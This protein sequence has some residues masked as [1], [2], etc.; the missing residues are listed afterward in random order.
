MNKLIF[1]KYKT[2]AK[3]IKTTFKCPYPM[4]NARTNITKQ[5]SKPTKLQ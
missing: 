5:K 2:K 4:T 1:T 3:I